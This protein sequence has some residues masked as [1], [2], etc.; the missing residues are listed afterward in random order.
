[1]ATS[2]VNIGDKWRMELQ[3]DLPLDFDQFT[4][5]KVLVEDKITLADKIKAKIEDLNGEELI[6]ELFS[7]PR[8]PIPEGKVRLQWCC[9]SISPGLYREQW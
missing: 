9:V 8:R 1:M 3:K 2:V 7:P 6:W 5:V 4:C